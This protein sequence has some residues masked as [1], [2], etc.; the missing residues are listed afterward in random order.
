MGWFSKVRPDAPYQ[1]VPRALETASYVELKA[2]CEAVGQPLSA[3]LYLYEGRLLISAIRGIAECG[4]IIGLSTDID[5]ETLGRTICDQL[6]AFRAQSPDDLRSRKLTDWEAYRASGAKSVKRFEERAWIVYI[7]AE[8]SLVR[9]EARPYR[10][11]HEEVFAAGRAS[12]DHADCGATL[13]RTLRAA[14]ALRAAGVI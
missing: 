14:E 1:P 12:P 10:S 6:L 8:H 5:D 11:P 7:R 4:P 2:R 13:K 3:S 9:F